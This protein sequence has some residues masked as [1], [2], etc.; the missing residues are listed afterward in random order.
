MTDESWNEFKDKWPAAY[1]DDWVREPEQLQGRECIRPEV[2]RTHTFGEKGS[3]EGQFY[4]SH[5][6]KIILNDV[7]VDWQKRDLTMYQKVT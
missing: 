3:S 2:S 6:K 7:N 4:E 1:W 5:L